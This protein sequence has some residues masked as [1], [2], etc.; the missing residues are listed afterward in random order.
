[1]LLSIPDDQLPYVRRTRLRLFAER[2]LTPVSAIA[3]GT[4]YAVCAPR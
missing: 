3:R 2:G 4:L 1:V